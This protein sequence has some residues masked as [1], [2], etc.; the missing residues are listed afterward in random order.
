MFLTLF[1]SKP[2]N[3]IKCSIH[4]SLLG[5]I[6][7]PLNNMSSSVGS[8]IPKIWKVLES[9]KINVPNHQPVVQK[10]GV[11]I[12]DFSHSWIHRRSCSFSWWWHSTLHSAFN[13]FSC[14]SLP[15]RGE[16]GFKH[17]GPW[18]WPNFSL[19]KCV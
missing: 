1:Y 2:H 17:G 9:H 14:C 19:A 16:A 8:I 18:W 5:G 4:F 13:A 3:S 15:R 10:D 12:D 11:C 7:T 6:P